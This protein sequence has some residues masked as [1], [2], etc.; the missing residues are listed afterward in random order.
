MVEDPWNTVGDNNCQQSAFSTKQ[1][2]DLVQ[3]LC[4]AGPKIDSEMPCK[5]FLINEKNES[6]IKS[7]TPIKALYI[8]T[9]SMNPF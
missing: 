4:R 7:G 3:L 8:N 2:E 1:I 6:M 9:N 5:Y